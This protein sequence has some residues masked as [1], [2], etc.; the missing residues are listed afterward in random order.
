MLAHPAQS[1][2]VVGAGGHGRELH[3]YL[4]DLRRAGWIGTLLGY[5]DDGVTAGTAREAQYSWAY[6]Q[7]RE[8]SR[9]I[10]H[11]FRIEYPALEYC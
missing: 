4:Q 1:L 11:C 9:A 8:P 2:Y 6:R 5:V 10:H 7:P 3:S